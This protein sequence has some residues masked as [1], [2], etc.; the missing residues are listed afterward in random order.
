MS[1]EN[2]N[3]Q[4][5]SMPEGSAPSAAELEAMF[6]GDTVFRGEMDTAEARMAQIERL[7]AE[8]QSLYEEFLASGKGWDPAKYARYQDITE[9]ID[10]LR[11]YSERHDKPRGNVFTRFLRALRRP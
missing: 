1:I 8:A 4:H 3:F 5:D 2:K 9:S 11:Q 10:L 6:S 7:E